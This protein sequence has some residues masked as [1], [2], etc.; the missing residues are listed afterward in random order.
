MNFCIH[1]HYFDSWCKFLRKKCILE[2]DRWRFLII[3][4]VYECLFII[5][6][7]NDYNDDDHNDGHHYYFILFYFIEKKICKLRKKRIYENWPSSSSII[8]S[9]CFWKKKKNASFLNILKDKDCI[10]KPFL[11]II[12]KKQNNENYSR[13][14]LHD[15]I[16]N[17]DGW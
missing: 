14:T 7:N 17:N 3:I 12:P 2:R 4:D 1:A 11:M 9:I 15:T 16:W 13:N 6:T 10:R 5:I 8:W